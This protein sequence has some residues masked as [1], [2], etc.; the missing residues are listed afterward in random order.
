[1]LALRDHG[2]RRVA[3]DVCGLQSLLPRFGLTLRL[4]APQA[5]IP[6]SYWGAPEAGVIGQCVYARAD[7]PVHSV[8]HEA[9]H[10]I[11]ASPNRRAKLFRDARSDDQE[12]I[13]VCYL[14]VLLADHLPGVGSERLM[15]DMDAWGYSFRLGSASK[16][17]TQDAADARIWLERA[18]LIDADGQLS[19]RLRMTPAEV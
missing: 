8:L 18:G 1:M 13:A 14:Q 12:E 5:D 17:F 10:I 2:V 9:A 15:R 4:V 16:W 11:C 6:A 19:W 7:T 3:D